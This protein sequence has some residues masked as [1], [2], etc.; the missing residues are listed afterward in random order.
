MSITREQVLHIARL[1]RLEL[2]Q[3]EVETSMRE[4]GDIL[5]YVE[6]LNRL[7]TQGVEPMSHAVA[8]A[9]A[10]RPDEP[11]SSAAIDALET[12]APAMEDRLFRVPPVIE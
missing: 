8:G 5:D 2:S 3:A 6:T 12:Q 7:D 9:T 1:A 4:L 10:L 11:R